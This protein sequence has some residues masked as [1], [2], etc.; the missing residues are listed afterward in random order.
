MSSPIIA[1]NRAIAHVAMKKEGAK[2]DLAMAM[3]MGLFSLFIGSS[4]YFFYKIAR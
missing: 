4:A 2:M 3:G 1:L